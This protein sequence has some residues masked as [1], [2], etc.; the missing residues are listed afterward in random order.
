MVYKCYKYGMREE[1]GYIHTEYKYE[2]RWIDV[3]LSYVDANNEVRTA[4]IKN[5]YNYT[6]GLWIRSE[7]AATQFYVLF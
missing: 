1:N 2:V 4:K 3:D 5:Y 7:I 6:Y